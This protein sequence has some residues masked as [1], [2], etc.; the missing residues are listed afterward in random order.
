VGKCIVLG[1]VLI[2]SKISV[3]PKLFLIKVRERVKGGRERERRGYEPI[4]RARFQT[5]HNSSNPI[6]P[7]FF[8][9]TPSSPRGWS[10]DASSRAKE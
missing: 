9:N 5:H 3:K 2:I 7:P 4:P 10:K 6:I 1:K 8:S